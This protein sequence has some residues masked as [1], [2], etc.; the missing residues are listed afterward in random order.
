MANQRSTFAKRQREQ[1]LLDKANAK[2]ERRAAKRAGTYVMPDASTV[3]P[4]SDDPP[5]APGAGDPPREE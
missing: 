1:K 5:P 2:K 3:S 4:P